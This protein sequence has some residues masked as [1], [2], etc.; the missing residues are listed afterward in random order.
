MEPV[1][2]GST[3]AIMRTFFLVSLKNSIS[4]SKG[5]LYLPTVNL[6]VLVTA[7]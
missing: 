2:R 5:V 1:V 3:A 6:T 4:I 7:L